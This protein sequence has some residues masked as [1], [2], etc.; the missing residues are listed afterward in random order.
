MA[1]KYIRLFEDQLEVLKNQ[2]TPE[3]IG[4]LILALSD[5]VF[6]EKQPSFEGNERFSWGFIKSAA[7]KQLE[8]YTA[9]CSVNRENGKLGGRPHKNP[10][11]FSKTQKTHL[12]RQEQEQYKNK[13][14]NTTTYNTPHEGNGGG[15]GVYLSGI[16]GELTAKQQEELEGF[17]LPDEVIEYAADEASA[18][19][20]RT[21]AYVR[22]ILRNCANEGVVSATEAKTRRKPNKPRYRWVGDE[23]EETLTQPSFSSFEEMYGN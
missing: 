20:K 12:L 22:G 19:G 21:W 23:E 1:I 14:K 10:D 7:D 2:H 13:N 16:I 5:Y 18:N 15:G 9:K 11:G 6:H 3:E 4:N 17:N 8:N